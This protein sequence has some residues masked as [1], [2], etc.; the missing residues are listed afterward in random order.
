MR[1]L[2]GVLKSDDD[3]VRSRRSPASAQLAELVDG[4]AGRRARRRARRAGAPRPLPPAVD[5]SAY[6]LVQEALTNC[7]RHAGPARVSVH[8]AVRRRRLRSTWS[9]T[10]LG[11]VGWSADAAGGHGLVAMRSACRWS[12][13]L[14]RSAPARGGLGG[15]GCAAG[16]WRG[17]RWPAEPG[18][19]VVVT[20]R[21][22]LADDQALVRAG[23]RMILEAQDD[24]EVVGEAGDG[25]EAVE[26]A[27]A[28]APRRRADG[29]PDAAP[30]RHR[31]HAGHRRRAPG[32]PG[33]RA[34]DVRSRRVRLR[35]AHAPARAASCSRTSAATTSSPRCASSRP[36]TRCWRRR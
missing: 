6:R 14:S 29:R 16:R 8:V 22:L 30:G 26:L 34:D 20:I 2:L 19:R 24:I 13:A 31:G 27:R 4:R 10:A 3:D 33:A 25:A 17:R 35:R 32:D 5:L 23:F 7:L 21:V 12:A 11:G 1:R 15:A 28:H 18:E 36:A 9:T